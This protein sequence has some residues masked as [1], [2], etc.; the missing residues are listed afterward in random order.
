MKLIDALKEIATDC[1]NTSEETANQSP[2]IYLR[3]NA[4]QGLQTVRNG[5]DIP[6][7]A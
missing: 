4:D 5:K 2:R 3:L 6:P 7:E 1:E